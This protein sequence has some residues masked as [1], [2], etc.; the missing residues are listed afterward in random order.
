MELKPDKELKCTIF[1][2]QNL[3]PSI[4][5]I[6]N[7]SKDYCFI[8]T[9]YINLFKYWE[10]FNNI[11]K[12][13]SIDKKRIVFILRQVDEK[14]E[15][16]E[17]ERKRREEEK[18]EIIEKL[19]GEYKF[20]LFFVKNLHAKMYLNE[21][22]VLI[23]SMN[24]TNLAKDNNYEIGCL[25]SDPDTSHRIVEEIIFGKILK[26]K[27]KEHKEGIS[28]DWLKEKINAQDTTVV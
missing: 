12:E 23:S 14:K 21:S 19:N 27:E 4:L 7:K 8:I 15:K 3:A 10:H 17:E 20:D 25:I 6:I 28:A 1:T 16:S 22:E 5:E 26:N 2:D 13:A 18:K 11:L 9:P 24:L